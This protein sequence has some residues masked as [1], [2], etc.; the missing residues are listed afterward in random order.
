MQKLMKN[1]KK[2]DHGQKFN[3]NFY[4]KIYEF[5]KEKITSSAKIY[6]KN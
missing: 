4:T 5:F 6:E 3:E 1:I 2:L